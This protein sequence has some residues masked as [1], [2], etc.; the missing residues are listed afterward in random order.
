MRT[1]L[2]FTAR[3]AASSLEVRGPH[4]LYSTSAS[5]RCLFLCFGAIKFD[6]REI[7]WIRLFAEPGIGPWS[8]YFIGGWKSSGDLAFDSLKFSAIGAPLLAGATI[9][10]I[11]TRLF[12]IHVV[13]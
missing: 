7:F 2:G 6:P 11:L 3:F 13:N 1:G 5:L 10:A 9:G 4:P 12:I 8:R